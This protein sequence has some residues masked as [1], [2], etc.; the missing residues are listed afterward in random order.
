MTEIP[1]P[2]PPE[3]RIRIAGEAGFGIKA[4]GQMLARTF[5]RGGLNVFD[6]TEYPSL[7][8][9][10]HNVY[11]LRVSPEPIHSHVRDVDVIVALNRDGVDRHIGELTEGGAV[12]FDSEVVP[13]EDWPRTE[14]VRRVPV[15]LEKLAADAGR[16]IMRNTVALGAICGLLDFPFERLEGSIRE[17]FG[18]KSEKVVDQNLQAA[19]SGYDHVHEHEEG[20]HLALAEPD[21]DGDKGASGE[22]AGRIVI[23]GNSAVGLGALAAGIGLYAAYP[24]TPASSL[25]HFMAANEREHGVVVKHT[26]DELAAMN[27]VVGGAFTG[28]RSMCGTSGGGFALMTEAFGL[29][30]V[31][32][33]AVVVM[34]SQ[35]PGPATGLPTWTEQSDLR[36]VLH[37]GQGEFP[38]VVLAPGDHT[39]CFDLTWEAFNLADRLQTPVV[40]MLDSFLSENHASIPPFDTGAV[41]IDRGKLITE[42]EVEDYLRYRVTDDGVSQLAVPGVKGAGQ[43]V[44]SY[45]HDE[46]GFANEDADM[47]EAQV[48]K[49][50][51]KTGL[52]RE[53]VPAPLL[54]GPDE[55]EIGILT[56]GSSMMPVRQAVAWLAEDGVD[57]Q[58]MQLRT[59]WPFPADEVKAFLE[60]DRPTLAVEGNSTG[61]MEGLVRQE[62]LAAPTHHLRRYDGRPMDP[63]WVLDKVKG[64]LGHA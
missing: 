4:S 47:R 58:V 2:D 18:A 61:Q 23:D 31:T 15:P 10:G 29:A 7:I 16:K 57:A 50:A 20:F 3:V 54:E 11:L 51:R 46:Y 21:R 33:S 64:V 55:A 35:R 22:Y 34:V 48:E 26:E 62:C 30:G 25:L 63:V 12:I 6:L 32:E 37:A 60:A 28:A 56:W 44:N 9:G 49:R 45:D 19:R 39:Q 42:G 52:A 27:A 14:A 59:L 1:R 41:R 40:L 36:T 8:R 53:I 17:Q 24:M 43:V 38:R 5:T 13:A